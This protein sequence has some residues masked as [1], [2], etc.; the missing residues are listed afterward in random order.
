MSIPPRRPKKAERDA[1]V[2]GA[3]SKDPKQIV[4]PKFGDDGADGCGDTGEDVTDT[5]GTVDEV[6]CTSK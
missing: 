5:I 6:P 3:N 1:S 2:C 4:F